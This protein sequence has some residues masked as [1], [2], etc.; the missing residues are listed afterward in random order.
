MG[1]EPGLLMELLRVPGSQMHVGRLVTEEEHD[2]CAPSADVGDTGRR[3]LGLDEADDVG[4]TVGLRRIGPAPE[5]RVAPQHYLL[6]FAEAGDVVGPGAGKRLSRLDVGRILR[7]GD[8]ERNRQFVEEGW[9]SLAQTEGDA[10]R[11]VVDLYA[12]AQVT[13]FPVIYTGGRT[14]DPVVHIRIPRTLAD[15][16]LAYD[17]TAD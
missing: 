12:L 11:D 2:V 5:V 8:D 10:P 9:I 17:P 7:D 15:R 3:G 16:Q 1:L 4:V 14:D 13:L 6:A